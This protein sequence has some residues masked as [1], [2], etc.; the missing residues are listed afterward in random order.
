MPTCPVCHTDVFDTYGGRPNARCTGCGALER[1]RLAWLVLSKLGFLRS[2]VRMLN[3]APEG[4]MLA[5]GAKQIGDG[6]VC[7]DVDPSLF[8]KWNRKVLKFDVCSDVDLFQPASFDIVMHNHV[9]E[10]VP[11]QVEGVMQRLHQLLVPGGVQIFSIPIM[12]ERAT[13]EDL[14]PSLSPETRRARFGQEDHLRMFGDQDVKGIIDRGF[15]GSEEVN[16]TNLFNSDVLKGA[17]IPEDALTTMSSHR[18]FAWRRV[19]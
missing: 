15:Q 4:F 8:A 18:I 19:V 11:C 14:N 16:V 5:Y 3:L 7:T 2:G 1:G 9:L 10:H 12:P 6:Y 13:V 17:G